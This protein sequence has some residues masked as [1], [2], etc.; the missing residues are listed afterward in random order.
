MPLTLIRPVAAW[1]RAWDARTS[2]R[3]PRFAAN[4]AS[5]AGRIRRYYGRDAVVIPPPVDTDFFTPGDDG[6]GTYDL[7]VSALAPYKRLKARIE[8]ISRD[9]RY[10]FMFGSLT[11]Q[12]TMAQVLAR[13][14]GGHVLLEE[15]RLDA[16]PRPQHLGR[17]LQQDVGVGHPP[18][19][20]RHRRDHRARRH[21]G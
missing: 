15:D 6:P 19:P 3:L 16:A 20:Y 17:P 21:P 5:V 2:V 9:P 13:L 11:V 12:D 8:T 18:P 1:L 4:R 14:E 7:V 10:A